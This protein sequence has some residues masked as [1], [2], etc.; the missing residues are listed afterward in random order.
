MKLFY[1]RHGK[2]QGNA[3]QNYIGQTESPLLD[4][5]VAAA[6]RVGKQIIASGEQINAIYTSKLE[7]QFV[8]AK[9]IASE[10]GY[11][12]SDIIFDDYLLE[13]AGGNFEGKPQAEFF[14]ASEEEQVVAGAES[15]QALSD[16]AVAIVERAK[17]EYPDGSVLF[18]GSAAIGEMIRAMIK[19]G[20]HTKMFDDGPLPNSELVIFLG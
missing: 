1:V 6:K 14:A 4:E 11:P 5:G 12:I 19:Y 3:A 10:I 8:T 7:R 2:T 18:V 17:S 20:D 15:F 13:R 16:R 9:I